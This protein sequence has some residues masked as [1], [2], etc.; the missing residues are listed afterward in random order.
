ML[1]AAEIKPNKIIS[2]RLD[3]STVQ[4]VA[5]RL[6]SRRRD[7]YTKAVFYLE[8]QTPGQ[9]ED[10]LECLSEDRG[11]LAVDAAGAYK[12][13]YDK[14][15]K[16]LAKLGQVESFTTGALEEMGKAIDEFVT[17]VP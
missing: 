11:S 1:V 14:L 5:A 2:L 16:S 9:E 13:G 15:Q 4:Q 6:R 10:S 3:D 12:A 8:D 7:K 17:L